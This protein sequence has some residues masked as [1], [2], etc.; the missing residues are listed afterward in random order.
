M[1][2]SQAKGVEHLAWRPIAGE[3][4]EVLV[5]A[6]PIGVVADE[7]EAEV[8]E[9]NADLMGAAGM[10]DGFHER[11]VTETFQELI[12]GPGVATGSVR[13][14]HAL[15]VSGM[16]SDG[17]ADF[18]LVGMETTTEQGVVCF[19]NAPGTELG[20]EGKMGSI[21]LCDHHA[22]AGVAIEAMNDAG[23]GD[24]SDAAELTLAV[25]QEGMDKRAM[26]MAGGGMRDH[27][28]RFI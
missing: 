7:R 6:F 9:V 4:G 18:A 23:T 15:A 24:A 28:R 22:A 16:T 2:E 17:S 21:V 11:G 26:I 3:L 10:E 14:R 13:D 1:L 12:A 19:Q 25:V 8:F 5:L 27:A 20:G